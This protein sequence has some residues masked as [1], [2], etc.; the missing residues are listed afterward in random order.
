MG[1]KVVGLLLR[2]T[3]ETRNTAPKPQPAKQQRRAT[4]RPKSAQTRCHDFSPPG[5]KN[6]RSSCDSCPVIKTKGQL[7]ALCKW[8]RHDCQGSHGLD[9]EFRFG[10]HH[11]NACLFWNCLLVSVVLPVLVSNERTQT[12]IDP[13]ALS[14]GETVPRTLGALVA[15]FRFALFLVADVVGWELKVEQVTRPSCGILRLLPGV[16]FPWPDALAQRVHTVL[17]TSEGL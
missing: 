2:R 11:G 12:W 1:P 5:T 3:T 9:L 14:A 10:G 13:S 4:H 7:E 17:A 15:V 16:V 8:K 6:N